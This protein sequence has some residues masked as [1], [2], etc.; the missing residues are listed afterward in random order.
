MRTSSLLTSTTLPLFAAAFVP[1]QTNLNTKTALHA[2]LASPL[3]TPSKPI[4]DPLGLYPEDSPERIDGLLV[5]LESVTQDDK[6]VVWD[7]L[8]LYQDES[9]VSSKFDSSPSLPFLARPA[10]LDGTLPGDRGFDPFNFSSDMNS[11]QWQRRAEIKHARLAML[12]AVG[13]PIAE[14]AHKSIASSFDLPS[15][16]ASADRVPSVLNDGLAH[17]GNPFFWIAAIAAASAIEME[18]SVNEARGVFKLDA[19]DISFGGKSAE[20]RHYMEEGE[21][22]NGRLA[23]LAVTGFAI[24]EA[25]LNSAVVDQIPIFFKPMNVVFEQLMNAQ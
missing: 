7:P 14:L 8:R 18:E 5:P 21:L 17:A 11:L 25:F 23:M 3:P 22:F 6:R 15:M 24:Q 16:L 10:H 20:G 2:E 9:Q 4:F 13:W 12:A 19:A 1:H